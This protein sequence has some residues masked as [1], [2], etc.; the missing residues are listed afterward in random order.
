ML[1][2]VNRD[3]MALRDWYY[4]DFLLIS[5]DAYVDHYSFANAVIGRWFEHLGYRV[6]IIAQPDVND[7]ESLKIMGKPRYGILISAGNMDSMI[8]HYT[9]AKKTRSGDL[10]S[11]GGKRGYRPDYATNVYVKMAKKAFPDVPI[12]IGGVEASLRRFAH[13]DFW[14]NKVLPSILISS[15]ADLLVYGMGELPLKE[16]AEKLAAGEGIGGCRRIAGVCYKTVKPPVKKIMEIPS[17]R[18]VTK[19][20]RAFAQAFAYIENENN[21]YDGRPIVQRHDD[22][23]LVANPPSRPLTTAEMDEIYD[24]PFENRWHPMYDDLGGIPAFDEVEFSLLSHR[25]CFGGCSFCSINFHQGKIIQNRSEKS[26]LAEAVRL[27]EKP[28][29][30]GYIHDVGGPTANFR[31]QGCEKAKKRGNCRNRQC[32]Y[33]EPCQNLRP[34]MKGYVQ[35]LQKIENLPK[36]KK[37][38]IR[39]GIRYDYIMADRRDDFFKHLVEHNVS[40]LLKVAPEHCSENVLAAME[41]PN[42]KVYRSFQDKFNRYT[43]SIGK[44]QYV[45][46][47]FIAAH[48]GSRLTDAIEL[49]MVMKQSGL[50]PEQVQL[51]IP[52]P[53]SRSTCMY[54]TGLNPRTMKPVYVPRSEE[55]R[56]MQRALLQY[57]EKKNWPKIREALE[58]AGRE[59]LIGW[60]PNFLVPPPKGQADNISSGSKNKSTKKRNSGRSKR[61]TAD[62]RQNKKNNKIS[63]KSNVRDKKTF[64][65]R[66]K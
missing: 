38:F 8:N 28:N 51:F 60:G 59:D 34:N 43:K 54:Y 52:T 11:P 27:T 30:K 46:P 61:K 29:F 15:G 17:L 31:G 40:G 36:V 62:I 47:Y 49:A 33:P 20:K 56:E 13:Y 19:N 3:E 44:K 53:G 58:K 2:P 63:G 10:Y 41:K 35:L 50:R 37:V 26:I 65:K 24:L 14:Q 12:I 1:L 23:Y 5:G 18:Q 9:A 42:F 7:E 22:I 21:F 64:D 45:L 55:E 32:L 66:R 4:L 48:P 57:S 16:V 25:G 39:S 6:G